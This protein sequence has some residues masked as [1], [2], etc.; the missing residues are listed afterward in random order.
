MS[1]FGHKLGCH[2]IQFPSKRFG[3]V[4][5]LPTSLAR[6]IPASTSAVMGGRAFTNAAGEIVEWKFPSFD[7]E[8]E[9]RAFAAEHGVTLA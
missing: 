2:V 6:E 4:G 1:L 5:S 8:A 9:A 3:Y 7:T